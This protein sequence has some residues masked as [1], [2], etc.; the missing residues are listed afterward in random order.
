MNNVKRAQFF[1]AVSRV[2]AEDGPRTGPP[3]TEIVR[4]QEP[5]GEIV[6]RLV[7]AGR[8]IPPAESAPTIKAFA[9]A[10][11]AAGY[12]TRYSRTRVRVWPADEAPADSAPDF[13]CR[14]R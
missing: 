7:R 1:Q 3:N 11:T 13:V 9:L 5:G 14:R 4:S 12:V 10:L 6:V 2:I 8:E